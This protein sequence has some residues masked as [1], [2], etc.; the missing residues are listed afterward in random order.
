VYFFCKTLRI[1]IHFPNTPGDF[2]PSPFLE[3]KK[4]Y[5]KIRRESSVAIIIILL[6]LSY[7]FSV[8]LNRVGRSKLRGTI[9]Y[10]WDMQSL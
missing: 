8:Q 2:F 5:S 4:R 9:L 6:L 7:K 10:L 1:E 3:E